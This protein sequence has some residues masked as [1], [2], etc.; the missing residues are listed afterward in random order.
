M[1]QYLLYCQ[2]LLV[3]TQSLLL[4]HVTPDTIYM[5]EHYAILIHSTFHRTLNKIERIRIRIHLLLF[6]SLGSFVQ[7]ML[8]Q[9]T[10]LCS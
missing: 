8:S 5:T 3:I 6:R 1:C 10:Q 2:V 7:S 4:A 9:C